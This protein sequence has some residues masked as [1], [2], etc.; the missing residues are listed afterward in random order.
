MRLREWV[1]LP[2][3]WIEDGGLKR[4]RWQPEPGYGADRIAALMTLIAIAHHAHEET[5]IAKITYNELCIITG[6]SRAKLANGLGILKSHKL[7]TPCE[8]SIY[9]LNNF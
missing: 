9:K 3:G 2:S 6:L 1:P 7:I 5:G 4:F 8:R